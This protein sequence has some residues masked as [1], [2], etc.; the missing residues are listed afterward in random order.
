MTSAEPPPQPTPAE[1]A[2]A[3]YARDHAARAAGIDIEEMALGHAVLGMTVRQNMVNGHDICHG[4]YLALLCDTAFAYACNS[5]NRVT[6]ASSFTIELL[7]PARLGDRLRAEAREVLRRGRS[8]VYDVCLKNALGDTIALF[9]GKSR[10][11]DGFIIPP[12]P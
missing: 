12:L 10:T 1:V 3:M 11:L 6:V 9:R 2:A 5:D 7:A 8:G 4:G